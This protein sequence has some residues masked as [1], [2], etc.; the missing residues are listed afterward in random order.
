MNGCNKF[1]SKSRIKVDFFV[2]IFLIQDVIQVNV[3][4]LTNN[5]RRGKIT[6]VNKNLSIR[7]KG[8]QQFNGPYNEIESIKEVPQLSFLDN[9]SFRLPVMDR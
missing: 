8:V 4:F 5:T 7:Y 3:I 1:F 6:F 2:P 9:T